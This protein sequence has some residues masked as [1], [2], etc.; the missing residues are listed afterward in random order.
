M[1][2]H[3]E[4]DNSKCIGCMACTRCEN[5]KC[6]RDFK[7]YAVRTEVEDLNCNRDA[8]GLCPVD[9]IVVFPANPE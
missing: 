6:G 4:L 7:A 8:A 9:A 3:V 1:T 2:F 5:F